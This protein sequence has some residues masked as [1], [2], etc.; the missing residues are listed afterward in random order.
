MG[1]A[2]VGGF[3]GVEESETGPLDLVDP[4]PSAGGDE[5]GAEGAEG[6]KGAEGAE[7]VGGACGC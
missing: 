6:I 3:C 2:V 7:V 4:C 1:K 5:T